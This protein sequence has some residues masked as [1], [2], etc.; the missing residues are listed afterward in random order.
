MTGL[1]FQARKKLSDKRRKT[2]KY[3]LKLKNII[4]GLFDKGTTEVEIVH[5]SVTHV[6][7]DALE[8]VSPMRKTAKLVKNINYIVADGI[9]DSIRRVNKEISRWA[10]DVLGQSA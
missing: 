1:E 9:F 2:M 10:S 5:N 7:F 3:L 4:Q 8:T 6:V